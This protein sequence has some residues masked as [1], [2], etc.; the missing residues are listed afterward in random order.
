M[1]RLNHT[2]LSLLGESKWRGEVS[3][4][5]Q[6][7]CSDEHQPTEDALFE[8]VKEGLAEW[9]GSNDLP[10]RYRITPAGNAKLI[11]F[12]AVKGGGR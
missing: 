3:M 10:L 6:I 8:L 12:C 2:L 1:K 9:F 11:E 4:C 5:Q 7:A